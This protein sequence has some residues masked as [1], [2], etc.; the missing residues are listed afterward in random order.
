MAVAM[1]I[2]TLDLDFRNRTAHAS[3]L[4]HRGIHPTPLPRD[5]Q[6]ELFA[7]CG[8]LGTTAADTLRL[9]GPDRQLIVEHDG[10]SRLIDGDEFEALVHETLAPLV[11]QV[12]EWVRAQGAPRDEDPPDGPRSSAFWDGIYQAEA[13]GWDLGAPSPPLERLLSTISP[14]PGGGDLAVLG[15]GRGHDVRAAARLGWRATGVDFAPRAIADARTLSTREVTDVHFVRADIFD[16]PP[17]LG[18]FDV[19]L[20]HTCFCAIDPSARDDYVAV[21]HRL[22]RPGGHL[23]G[24]F[25]HHGREGGPPF[26]T[27]A[28]ELHTRFGRAF[29]IVDLAPAPDSPLHRTGSELGAVFRRR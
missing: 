16:L 6:S 15:C 19:V 2:A 3:I 7:A 26:D 17:D 11:R 18:P 13:G 23:V 27:D 22:L 4:D 14:P 5:L 29:E 20:E 8:S 25:Y 24:V 28:D 9:M 12:L 1:Q 21:V 10:S